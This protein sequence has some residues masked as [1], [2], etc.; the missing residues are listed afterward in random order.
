MNGLLSR[1]NFACILAV[2]VGPISF[3]YLATLAQASM[4]GVNDWIINWT[5]KYYDLE[6]FLDDLKVEW[7]VF[8][9]Q[10]LKAKWIFFV[11]LREYGL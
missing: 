8:V 5:R 4:V 3:S 2:I 11:G 9:G 7:I 6:T 1:I 10:I